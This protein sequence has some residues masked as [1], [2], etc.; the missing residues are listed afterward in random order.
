MAEI[1]HEKETFI[2]SLRSY[3]FVLD[4]NGLHGVSLSKC[5]QPRIHG[6]HMQVG[7]MGSLN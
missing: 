5:A 3:I 6:G 2:L 4:E 1:S 7:E